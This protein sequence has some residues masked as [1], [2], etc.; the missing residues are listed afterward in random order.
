MLK[1][2]FKK[3]DLLYMAD[4]CNERGYINLDIIERDED[5]KTDYATHTIKINDW[6]PSQQAPQTASTMGLGRDFDSQPIPGEDFVI[7]DSEEELF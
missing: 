5:R 7:P 2:S 6:K 3:D 4:N 1:V